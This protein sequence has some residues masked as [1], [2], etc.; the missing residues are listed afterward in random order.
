MVEPEGMNPRDH[1]PT[2]L[3]TGDV[4]PRE[5]RSLIM[6]TQS[7][8]DAGLRTK[9]SLLPSFSHPTASQSERKKDFEVVKEGY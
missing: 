5:L 2:W 7:G 1:N 6:A 4:R 3:L 9:L 8:A